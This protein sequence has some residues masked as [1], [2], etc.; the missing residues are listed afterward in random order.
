LQRNPLSY[1]NR[2]T[3]IDLSKGS[4]VIDLVKFPKMIREAMNALVTGMLATYFNTKSDRG[5][6]IAIDEGGAFLRDPQL[7]EMVLQVLTQGR[8]YDIGLLFATQ[9]CSDLEK[10]KLSQEFMTNTPVKIVLGFDLDKKSIGYIKDFLLLNDTASKDLYT[11]AKGQGIIKIGDTHAAIHFIPSDEEYQ[12]IKGKKKGEG[13]KKEGEQTQQESDCKIKEAFVNIVKEH[14]ILYAYW[15]EGDNPAHMLQMMGYKPYT[16]QNV[17]ARGDVQGW[18]HVDIINENGNIKNQTEDH[19]CTVTQLAGLLIEMGF[20]NVR[21]NHFGDVDVS[22][23]LHGQTY[24]FEYEH[25]ESHDKPEII[26]KKLRAMRLYDNVLFIGSTANEEQLIEAVGSDFVR[27]RGTQLKKWL[28]AQMT[29]PEI[30]INISEEGGKAEDL[31][32]ENRPTERLLSECETIG[33]L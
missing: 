28:A 30:K 8:S 6:T 20:K 31:K 9:N 2:Q 21:I 14:K 7:A 17:I 25:S 3:D 10:A 22:G 5:T 27:R 15:L 4:T 1:M 13:E 26:E 24:G 11:D 33:A 18:I 29:E 19:Y 23:E 12:I 16:P 32:T